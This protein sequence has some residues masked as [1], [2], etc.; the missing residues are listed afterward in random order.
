MRHHGL[1]LAGFLMAGGASLAGIPVYFR[2]RGSMTRPEPVP[3]Y[4]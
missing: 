3:D 4:R 2:M 1:I